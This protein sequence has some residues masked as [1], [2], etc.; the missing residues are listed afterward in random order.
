MARSISKIIAKSD[1][2][3]YLGTYKDGDFCIFSSDAYF[4]ELDVGDKVSGSFD[5]DDGSATWGKNLTQDIDVYLY[6]ESWGMSKA[7][8]LEMLARLN[9]PTHIYT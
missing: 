8:A 4:E 2:G 9:N 5:G 3:V 7:Q 6:Y 1:K